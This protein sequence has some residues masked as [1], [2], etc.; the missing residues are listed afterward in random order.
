MFIHF[1]VDKSGECDNCGFA[2]AMMHIAA[3]H[4]ERSLN[5]CSSCFRA[6][7]LALK[8]A[9]RRLRIKDELQ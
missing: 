4:S 1:D 3:L 7:A 6:L 8:H 2:G 5:L 9:T